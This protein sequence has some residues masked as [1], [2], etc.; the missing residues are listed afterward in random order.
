MR[1]GVQLSACFETDDK[2]NTVL[3]IFNLNY[4]QY[5][6]DYLWHTLSHTQHIVWCG[7]NDDTIVARDEA[8]LEC[9]SKI[10]VWHTN[11]S[12]LCVHLPTFAMNDVIKDANENDR[13]WIFVSEQT[14]IDYKREMYESKAR[15]YRNI[16]FLHYSDA[17]IKQLFDNNQTTDS[18]HYLLPFV[19]CSLRQFA[20]HHTLEKIYDVAFVGYDGPY[21]DAIVRELRKKH[22]LIDI[23]VF[24]EQRDELVAQSKVLVNIHFSK[25]Y[26]TLESLRCVMALLSGTVVVSESSILQ[27]LSE[28]EQQIDFFAYEEL[29][30][31]VDDAIENYKDRSERLKK[32]LGAYST[33]NYVHCKEQFALSNLTEIK[34]LKNVE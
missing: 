26:K 19:P 21:R 7:Y 11:F 25:Q 31:A 28:V 14:S 9:M 2:M 13:L 15:R 12:V 3:I 27:T 32:F 17:N 8:Q 18:R 1:C 6:H 10:A 23:K 33:T 24:G 22:K 4:I 5:F 29:V 20:K 16:R 34:T 30:R